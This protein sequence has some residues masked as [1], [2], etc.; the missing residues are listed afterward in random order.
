MKIKI[1][2]NVGQASF[3]ATLDTISEAY[4]YIKE[5]VWKE[6]NF[7]PNTE[8]SLSEYMN[9]LA[10]MRNGMCNQFSNRFFKVEKMKKKKS[11]NP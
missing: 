7:F 9:Q 3:C 10:K 8:E 6:E 4:E 11:A 1:T 5:L 2:Y